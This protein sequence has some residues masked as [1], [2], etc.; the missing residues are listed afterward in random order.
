M[1]LLQEIKRQRAEILG[2]ERKP[3][4]KGLKEPGDNMVEGS[5]HTSRRRGIQ[6]RPS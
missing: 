5:E 2:R 6:K 1:I 4:M 3:G